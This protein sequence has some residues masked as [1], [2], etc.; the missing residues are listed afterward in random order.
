[1]SHHIVEALGLGHRYVD[2]TQ[3]LAEVS[4]RIHHGESVG[5]IGA[6]GAGKS[7]LLQHLNGALMPT[8]GEV[9]IGEVPLRK[10]TLRDIRR[11]VGMVFQDSDDQL[12]TPTVGEDVAFGPRNLG[13]PPAD[14]EARVTAALERVE[15]LQLRNRPP[16]R[17]SGGEKRRAA[18]ATVLSMAPDILVLDEPSAGLD[19]RSRRHLIELLKAFQHTK[20]I[21]THDL[22]LVL[23]LC[24]RTLVLHEG[25]VKADGTTPAI[26]ADSALLEACHLEKPLSMQGCPICG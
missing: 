4:F 1:M 6:N 14:V 24:P 7:T 22:D 9:R 11:T 26:F 20:I 3:A 13:L 2:G 19:P 25:R 17:L 10:E 5:V 15:L 16:Y 23:D 12:F 21:A 18:I 8:A